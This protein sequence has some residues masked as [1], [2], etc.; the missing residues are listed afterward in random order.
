MTDPKP[1]NSVFLGKFHDFY[2]F[3]IKIDKTKQKQLL[4]NFSC[5]GSDRQWLKDM[6]MSDTSSSSEMSD[7]DEYI[8]EMLKNHVREKRIR[9]RYHQNPSVR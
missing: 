2:N 6:L 1:V 9:E 8:K 3:L 4:Y 5:V 7:E